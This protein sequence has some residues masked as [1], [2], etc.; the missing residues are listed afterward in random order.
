ME[1][2]PTVNDVLPIE[3]P[4]GG[5]PRAK[6]PADKGP[7]AAGSGLERLGMFDLIL[8]GQTHLTE[9][10]RREETLPTVIQK[11]LTLSL[12]GLGVHGLVV[13][14]AAQVL[15]SGLSPSLHGHP[16]AWMPISFVLAFV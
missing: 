14:F 8:R 13:G 11:L 7:E 3:P 9:V 12:L 6:A 4:A 1:S 15:S 5:A 16:A 10:L 2:A